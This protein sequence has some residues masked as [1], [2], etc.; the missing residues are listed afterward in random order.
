M[1]KI[2]PDELSDNIPKKCL[3]CVIQTFMYFT[4]CK[5]LLWCLSQIFT[6][7]PHNDL[8]NFSGV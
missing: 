8:E 6:G 1:Y 3:S 5:T 2:F 7:V 4:Q